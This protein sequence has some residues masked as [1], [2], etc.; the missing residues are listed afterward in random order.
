M[1]KSKI[2]TNEE[3]DYVKKYHSSASK[4]EGMLLIMKKLE[5]VD[6]STSREDNGGTS[7][8]DCKKS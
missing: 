6:K 4:G 8:D 3:K 5:D 7:L 1:P 2:K